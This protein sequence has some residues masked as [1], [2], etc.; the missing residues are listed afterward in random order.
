VAYI[1]NNQ[2]T[3]WTREVEESQ[4]W[5]RKE[6]RNRDGWRTNWKDPQ[7]RPRRSVL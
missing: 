6:G 4:K 2:Q 7:R 3:G 5:R 1:G